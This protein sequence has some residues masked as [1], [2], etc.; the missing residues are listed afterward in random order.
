MNSNYERYGA[1]S[2]PLL[3]NNYQPIPVKGKQPL[4]KSWTTLPVT[5]EQVGGWSDLHPNESVGIL[6]GKGEHPIFAADFDFYDAQTCSNL[7]TAF[8]ERFGKG[9]VR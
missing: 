7:T 5:K 3:K 8:Q 2:F 4:V 6:T 1:L 9:L